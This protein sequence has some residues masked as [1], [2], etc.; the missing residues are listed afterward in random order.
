MPP[1][2]S[3]GSAMD[4]LLRARASLALAKAEQVEGVLL[5]DLCYQAQQAAEKALKGFYLALG[6]PFPFVHS[7]DQLMAGLEE[8]GVEIPE[9]V[10]QAIILTRY[11]V[12]TRYPGAHEPVE[13]EE[14]R[15][16]IHLAQTVL[17]WVEAQAHLCETP[18]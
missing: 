4:W 11:A 15:E 14:Y 5:E 12:E 7:L 3:A 13:V 18:Q 16:T 1:R 10:D 6:H 9:T 2:P 8:L 17:A